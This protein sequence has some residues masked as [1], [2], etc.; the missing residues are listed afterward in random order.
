MNN[1]SPELQQSI[2]S[3]GIL[4]LVIL[5]FYMILVQ[6][7]ISTERENTEHIE[8]LM[9]QSSRLILS[10]Q[11]SDLIKDEIGHL[12]KQNPSKTDFLEDKK[13]GTVAA[14][15]Q[16]KIKALIESS[17]G[18]LV[19]THTL[20]DRKEGLF[21]EIMVKVHMRVDIHALRDVFC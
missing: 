20:T 1:F 16:K 3:L 11:E 7:A 15:L 12:K 6:P 2:Y 8:D 9:F 17:G 5:A 13:L 4:L 10:S 18:D 21:S 14:D 19:S